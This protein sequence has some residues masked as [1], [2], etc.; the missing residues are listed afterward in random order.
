MSV[1]ISFKIFFKISQMDDFP[2]ATS[3]RRLEISHAF[4]EWRGSKGENAGSF[5]AGRQ[6]NSGL[7]KKPWLKNKEK[8]SGFFIKLCYKG[9]KFLKWFL[10]FWKK[11]EK[12]GLI[13]WAILEKKG[14]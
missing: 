11:K 3:F 6:N 9:R 7:L 8:S 4:E 14:I 10:R 12:M 2:Y 5:L 13:C 1:S